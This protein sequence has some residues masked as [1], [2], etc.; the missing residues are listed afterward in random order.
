MDS[1]SFSFEIRKLSSHFYSDYSRDSYPEILEKELRPYTCLLIET[2]YG[3]YICIPF[4]TDISHK[5]SYHFKSTSRSVHHR[6]GLDYS[7]MVLVSDTDYFSKESTLI[8]R[9]EYVETQKNIQKIYTHAVAYLN[10]YVKFVNGNS[11]LSPEELR[12]RYQF[13]TLKY[14]HDILHL[15]KP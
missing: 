11:S 4:R 9:D 14:F 1:N 6:S 10:E 7:K 2:N 3:Y 12:R 5:Y 8:D 15:P 13:S